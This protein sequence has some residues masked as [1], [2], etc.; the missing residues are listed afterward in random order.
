MV[1]TK[2]NKSTDKF[3]LKKMSSCAKI[4]DDKGGSVLEHS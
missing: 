2:A 3:W 1:Y 4:T